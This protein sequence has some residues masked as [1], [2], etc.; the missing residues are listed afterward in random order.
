MQNSMQAFYCQNY[1]YKC[2]CLWYIITPSVFLA[3]LLYCHMDKVIIIPSKFIESICKKQ[4]ECAGAFK[5]N[6]SRQFDR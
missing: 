5:P 2:I 6:A 3:Y 4:I 1:V